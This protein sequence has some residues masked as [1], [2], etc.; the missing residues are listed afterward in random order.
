M[1]E[2][3]SEIIWQANISVESEKLKYNKQTKRTKKKK[4]NSF[5]QSQKPQFF[6]ATDSFPGQA[7]AEV[8][9]RAK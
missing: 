6:I 8:L 1:T 9:K 3:I 2:K 4:K 5:I 7:H